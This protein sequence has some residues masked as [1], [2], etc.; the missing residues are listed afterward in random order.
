[1][2]SRETLIRATRELLAAQGYEATSPREI[3]KRSGVGQGSFYH[4]FGSKAELASS[5][6]SELALD[7]MAEF[8]ALQRGDD[9]I[10][11]GYLGVQRDALAG[12]RIG[13]IAMEASISDERI[14][15]PLR[16][17]FEHLREVMTAAFA[18]ASVSDPE[19]LA[20]LAI[21]A[22]QGGFVL[23]RATGDADAQSNAT[24]ALEDL[25]AQLA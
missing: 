10:V 13:R 25:L 16:R 20:D 9:G 8:D 21:A 17:Y 23:A 4:H 6:L 5:A 2:S 22:V 24:S 18:N 14:R 11:S 19:R 7:M 1:M 12:C 3:Q 15:E